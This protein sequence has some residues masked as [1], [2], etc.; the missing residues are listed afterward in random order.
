MP[1]LAA[2][3]GYTPSLVYTPANLRDV[4]H[5]GALL[6]VEVYL[7]IDM[8]GH[9]GSIHYAYPDLIAAANVQPAWGNFSA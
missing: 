6:G 8:P 4:Q 5:Y 2:K 9:I 1:D 7:E 3:G